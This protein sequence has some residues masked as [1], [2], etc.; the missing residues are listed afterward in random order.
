M[1]PSLARWLSPRAISGANTK[2]GDTLLRLVDTTTVYA[3]A[4]VPESDLPRLRQLTGAELETPEGRLF[5]VRRLVST[6]RV[7]D[8][9]SR[10]IPVIYEV[11]NAGIIAS[12][13]GRRYRFGCSILPIRSALPSTLRCR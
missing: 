11:N 5:P 10:T 12:R 7:V 6:G 1:H 8:P 3:S 2:A 13:S 9:E 4:N